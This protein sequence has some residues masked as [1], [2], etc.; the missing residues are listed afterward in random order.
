MSYLLT[1]RAEAHGLWL[2]AEEKYTGEI[3]ESYFEP[4]QIEKI[5]SATGNVKK[6]P[7]FTKML[8]S[9]LNRST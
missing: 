7:V 5:T 2:E 3:W 9:A 6:F 4:E 1:I 8:I